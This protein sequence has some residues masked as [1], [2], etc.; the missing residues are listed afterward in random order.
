MY[1]SLLFFVALWKK[2]GERCFCAKRLL[3]SSGP[4]GASVR[5]R[6]RRTRPLRPA[7]SANVQKMDRLKRNQ[8][9][10]N[11]AEGSQFWS[12]FGI[13]LRYVSWR[14]LIQLYSYCTLT[15]KINQNGLLNASRPPPCGC[16]LV[17]HR[18]LCI[19]LE[20]LWNDL[21]PEAENFGTSSLTNAI[22]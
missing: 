18:V 4:P 16:C 2:V 7:R 3:R 19:H 10:N 1:L 12:I 20:A 22:F 11:P 17:Q 8:E 13:S 14:N 15:I 6:P 5:P 9:L 21:P